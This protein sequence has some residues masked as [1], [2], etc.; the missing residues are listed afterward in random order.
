[1]SEYPIGSVGFSLHNSRK[2]KRHQLALMVGLVIVIG[3][4]LLLP[5]LSIEQQFW[6]ILIPVGVFGLSH[7][8]ADPWIVRRMAGPGR[9]RQAFVLTAY[10]IASALFLGLVWLSPVTALVVFLAMSIWHFGFTDEA[11]LSPKHS[12]RLLWLSGSTPVVAP[13]VGHPEQTGEL[14]AWLLAYDTRAV[15]DVVSLAGPALAILWLLGFATLVLRNS[16]N[17]SARVFSELV[18]VAV[19]LVLLPPLLAFTFYFCLIH[20]FRHFLSIAE[21][22]SLDRPVSTHIANLAKKAWPATLA[23]IALGLAGWFLL[24]YWQPG[25]EL[26]IQGVRVMFW[27]LAALTLP[28]CLL[29]YRWWRNGRSS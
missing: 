7:G 11:Y 8:G 6:L 18:L 17:L 9:S 23:A 25:S 3:V 4:A 10:L 19:A 13:M 27:G 21:T 5:P 2:G 26:L 29:V 15:I 22:E 1:M 16:Q 28:H 14:F 20:T 24:Q 12:T